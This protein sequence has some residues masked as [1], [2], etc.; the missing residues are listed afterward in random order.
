MSQSIQEISQQG[1]LVA[2]SFQA[3]GSNGSGSN[4]SGSATSG[5][6]SV[7]GLPMGGSDKTIRGLSVKG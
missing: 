4:A 1:T 2:G 6:G 3:S 5:S 7:F